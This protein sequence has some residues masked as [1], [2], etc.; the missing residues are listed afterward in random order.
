MDRLRADAGALV[1]VAGLASTTAA[2]LAKRL[3][4][5]QRR[6]VETGISEIVRHERRRWCG[7]PGCGCGEFQ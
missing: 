7:C 3:S 1:P 5:T 4:R 6:A 2:G